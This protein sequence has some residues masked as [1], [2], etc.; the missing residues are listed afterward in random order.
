MQNEFDIQMTREMESE[1]S[2]MC[3]LSQGIEEKGI[4]KGIQQ[5]RQDERISIL[6]KLVKSGKMPIDEALETL[7]IP[8]TDWQ[9]YHK[10]LAEQ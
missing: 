1:V 3:N 10:L 6:K 5:G 2:V 8:K 7:D 4:Q 9:G